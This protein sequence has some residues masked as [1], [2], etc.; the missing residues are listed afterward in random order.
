MD[1][2]TTIKK[3]AQWSFYQ[4]TGKTIEGDIDKIRH[5]HYK[6]YEHFTSKINRNCIHYLKK[7]FLCSCL[8]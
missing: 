3:Y 4:D 1:P 6:V 8:S 7:I 2:Q 5:L